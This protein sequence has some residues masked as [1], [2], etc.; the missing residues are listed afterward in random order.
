MNRLLVVGLQVPE[1]LVVAPG[2][3]DLARHEAVLTEAADGLE[4]AAFEKQVAVLDELA[5]DLRCRE[6][7]EIVD[8]GLGARV[9]ARRR[10]EAREQDL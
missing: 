3:D 8:D 4:V 2:R 5:V 6:R 7:P 10:S 1:K 9:V